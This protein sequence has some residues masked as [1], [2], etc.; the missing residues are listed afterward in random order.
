M[1]K[2]IIRMSRR[3]FDRLTIIRGLIGC[4]VTQVIAAEVLGLSERQ[5]RRLVKWIREESSEGIIHRSRGD[6]V[7]SKDAGGEDC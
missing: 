4:E 5:V 3:E 6:S 1:A 2:D 7:G